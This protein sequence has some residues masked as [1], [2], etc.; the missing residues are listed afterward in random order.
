MKNRFA[1]LLAVCAAFVVLPATAS[2]FVAPTNSSVVG[3]SGVNA[4]S[5]GN[6]GDALWIGGL[7]NSTSTP[8]SLPPGGYASWWSAPKVAG[9]RLAAISTDN[10]TRTQYLFRTGTDGLKILRS[11]PEQFSAC[12]TRENVLGIDE[13][14]NVTTY[15]TVE[16]RH[17]QPAR[18]LLDLSQSKIVRYAASGGEP[19]ELSPATRYLKQ[20][21]TRWTADIWLPELRGSRLLFDLPG[22]NSH[23]KRIV[24]L[25]L[26]SKRTLFRKTIKRGNGSVLLT[27]NNAV[28]VVRYKAVRRGTT[29]R[30]TAR[31]LPFSGKHSRL[32]FSGGDRGVTVCGNF[33]A[34]TDDGFVQIVNG[35]GRSV[36]RRNFGKAYAGGTNNT[37]CSGQALHY[38]ISANVAESGPVGKRPKTRTG[39]VDLRKF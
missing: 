8:L 18:C 35:K 4:F 24:V 10:E 13:A 34:L 14:G 29:I 12:Q 37:V 36:Y 19:V 23:R 17:G 16:K 5:A 38:E 15:R 22:S 39:T 26:N 6:G 21:P 31:R 33:L 1:A 30:T 2:A 20:I 7:F 32:L 3:I 9:D 27:D 28:V 11:W 25:D